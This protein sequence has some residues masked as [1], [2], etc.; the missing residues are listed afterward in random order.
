M[1]SGS[2]S[3]SERAFAEEGA[4][5]NRELA[6]HWGRLERVYERAARFPWVTVPRPLQHPTWEDELG[7]HND[8]EW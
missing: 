2:P 5:R 8:G 4:A 1:L 7:Q 3:G 6:D